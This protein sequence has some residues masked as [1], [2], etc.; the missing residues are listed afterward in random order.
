MKVDHLARP[1]L[2]RPQSHQE[3]PSSPSLSTVHQKAKDI[4]NAHQRGTK[5]PPSKPEIGPEQR[6]GG[7]HSAEARKG[8]QAM[9]RRSRDWL[10]GP[11]RTGRRPSASASALGD[12]IKNINKHRQGLS[13]VQRVPPPGR[14]EADSACPP[15]SP[16]LTWRRG[17]ISVPSSTSAAQLSPTL[18]FPLLMRR[19]GGR[20]GLFRPTPTPPLHKQASSVWRRPGRLEG[21]ALS[22]SMRHPGR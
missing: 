14:M 17:T 20:C 2:G 22:A 6:D 13:S 11:G 16:G 7:F 8:N 1:A 9:E 5:A 12:L 10:W 3:G 4:T 18:E 21:A 19:P 15:R